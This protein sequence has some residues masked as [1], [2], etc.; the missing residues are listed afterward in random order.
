MRE[1]GLGER[2]TS[3]G[4]IRIVR[5]HA[6]QLGLE[7]SHF[8]G[9][10]RWSDAQLKHAISEGRSWTDV[11]T[12]LGLS[13]SSG[14]AQGHIKSHAVRLGLDLSHLRAGRPAEPPAKISHLKADLRY[15]RVAGPTMAATWFALRGCTV[16]FPAE[17]ATYDLLVDT[18][19]GIRRVQVK[20]STSHTKDGWMVTVGRHLNADTKRG[21]LTAYD[22][23]SI[24]LFFVIDGD[25]AMYLI[26]SRA[27]AGRVRVLIRAYATYIVGNAH[28][29]LGGGV[30]QLL[31]VT[32][33]VW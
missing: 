31:G 15:L 2:A 14:N 17:P 28:G 33:P 8:R 18:P 27:L 22:P 16:S 10:R 32:R 30:N 23:E 1:L 4:A 25:F 6:S 12:E 20:T 11:L 3:A 5:R 29:L 19:E 24:D 7:T 26:P 9:K 21:H 13:T